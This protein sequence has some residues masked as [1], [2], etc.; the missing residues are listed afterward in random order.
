MLALRPLSVVL[1]F[2]ST[3]RR[4]VLAIA[5]GVATAFSALSYLLL[6]PVSLVGCAIVAL[7]MPL[8]AVLLEILPATVVRVIA[9]ESGVA[10]AG[11]IL[12]IS[13]LLA[14]FVVVATLCFF[15]RRRF[16]MPHDS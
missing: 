16:A 4:F 12:G 13:T 11:L 10:A 8:A 15:L 6:F 14:W 7:G 2:M 1:K 3:S 5:V 9:P